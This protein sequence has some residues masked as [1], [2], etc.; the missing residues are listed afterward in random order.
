LEGGDSVGGSGPR[1]TTKVCFSKSLFLFFSKVSENRQKTKNIA[2]SDKPKT[3]RRKYKRPK[4]G[5]VCWR[6]LRLFWLSGLDLADHLV[7][8]LPITDVEVEHR[9]GKIDVLRRLKKQ[10]VEREQVAIEDLV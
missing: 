6:I 10:A 8:I 3:R 5:G 7:R 1:E 9:D 4:K 2:K